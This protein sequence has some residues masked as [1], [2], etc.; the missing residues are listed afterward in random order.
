M[1]DVWNAVT[2]VGAVVAAVAAVGAWAGARKGNRTSAR[3][4]ELQQAA[5]HERLTP[6]LDFVFREVIGGNGLACSLTVDRTVDSLTVEIIRGVDQAAD[7]SII[8]L[9]EGTAPGPMDTLSIRLDLAGIPAGGARPITLWSSD[10]DRAAGATVRLRTQVRRGDRVWSD[11]LND[12]PIPADV[13]SKTT[14]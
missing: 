14:S 2:G 11:L 13:L 12:L 5:D 8:G 3:S 1:S 9:T 6:R 10:L 7:S 4:L